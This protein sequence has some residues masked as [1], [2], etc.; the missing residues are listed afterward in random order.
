MLGE[1]QSWVNMEGEGSAMRR[2]SRDG[3]EEGARRAGSRVGE[4]SKPSGRLY[5]YNRTGTSIT[6]QVPERY[7]TLYNQAR[8]YQDFKTLL[9]ANAR[10]PGQKR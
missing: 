10:F 1:E 2:R 9:S 8:T 7:I 4:W 5:E 6:Y 3:E